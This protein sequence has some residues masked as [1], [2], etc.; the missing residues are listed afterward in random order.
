M[1]KIT[2]YL[3]FALI[4]VCGFAYIQYTQNIKHKADS[5]RWEQNT[6]EIQQQIQQIN[7]TYR[8]FKK[9]MDNKTDSILNLARIKP[10]NVTQITN[11]YTIYKDTTINIL[12][13]IYSQKTGTYPFMDK[14]GCFEF[15]GFI[16]M[17][18]TTPEINI[19]NRKFNSDFTEIEHWEKDTLHFLR[20]KFTN[21]FQKK[22]LNYTIIDNCSGDKRI[23]K[24]NIK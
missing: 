9:Y 7:Y 14:K 17:V 2:L 20:I 10:K 18:D 1:K 16:N 19:K 24:I 23:K 4:I 22:W 5:K 11:N 21:P 12:K 3:I 15:S 13:P 6:I 8:D